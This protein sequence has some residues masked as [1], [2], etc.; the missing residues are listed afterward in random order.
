M[1][2][3]EISVCPARRRSQL[4]ATPL[5]RTTTQQGALRFFTNACSVIGLTE[6]VRE[7]LINSFNISLPYVSISDQL[8]NLGLNFV[9]FLQQAMRQLIVFNH[10]ALYV[11]TQ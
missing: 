11:D 1:D 9:G 2:L 7:K 3:W 4:M 5:T 6:W 10:Q 8:R